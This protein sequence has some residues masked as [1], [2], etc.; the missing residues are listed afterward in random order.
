MQENKMLPKNMISHVEPLPKNMKDSKVMEEYNKFKNLYGNDYVKSIIWTQEQAKEKLNELGVK[1]N[2]TFFE[3]YLNS[4]YD[5]DNIKLDQLYG[6]SEI[7]EDYKNPFWADKYPN[8]TDRYLQISSI[9]G[10][11]SYFYDKETDAVYSV[12]WGEMDDFMAGKLEPQ[13]KSFY[14]FLEWYYCED[15]DA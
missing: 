2:S 9:E 7:Y 8:I 10:E 13:W 12:D 15:E 6:L 14:D 3:L 4:F 11:H 1:P 5:P